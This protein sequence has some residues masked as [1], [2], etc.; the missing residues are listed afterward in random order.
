VE[1]RETNL[2]GSF[3]IEL[4]RL[5]DERGFFARSWCHL[6]FQKH[7]LNTDLVQCNISYNRQ[8]RT[9]RGM[10]FQ[11]SPHAES[12]LVRCTRG[13]IFDVIVDLRNDS[14]TYLQWFSTELSADNHRMLYI[15]EHFAHGFQTLTDD[16]E[17]FY[18]MGNYFTPS[19]AAG[20]RWNDPLVGITWPLSDPILSDRDRTFP[21]LQP[22][23][24][25]SFSREVA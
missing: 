8:K 4:A 14:P 6:E 24:V 11:R 20:F 23:G 21:D 25:T 15:P 7:G 12:K 17:V 18:Q 3:V 5:E 2:K 9:L 13:G 22:I 19:A 16:T 10:H 1:F